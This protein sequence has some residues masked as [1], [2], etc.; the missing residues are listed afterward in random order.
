VMGQL[1]PMLHS[2]V[3]EVVAG[4]SICKNHEFQMDLQ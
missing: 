1:G 4:A 2:S 3:L